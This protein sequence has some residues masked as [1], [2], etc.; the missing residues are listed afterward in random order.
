MP[1]LARELPPTDCATWTNGEL[2]F[3]EVAR[4]PYMGDVVFSAGRVKGH[5]VDTLFL[6]WQRG[7]T[8]GMLLLR[9]DEAAA[10]M[11]CLSGALWSELVC[12]ET[13]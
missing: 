6:R 7:E 8:G 1:D 12:N 10:I 5:R 3:T 4:Q 9:S 13:D 2:T 11:H